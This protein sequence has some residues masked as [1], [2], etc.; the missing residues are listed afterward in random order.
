LW[1]EWRVEIVI[2][3][4]V[5]LAIFLLVEQ[6]NIRQSL[7]AGLRTSVKWLAGLVASAGQTFARLTQATT[8]SDM[9]AYLL[10][11]VVAGLA[12]WR[13]RHR[14]LTL[15]RFSDVACPRCGSELTR[16]HRHRSDRMLSLFVPLRRYQCKN[17]ECAWRG[18]RVYR[19]R[20]GMPASHQ[21]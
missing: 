8:V 11:L 15:P 16:I 21:E 13:T 3:L 17:H 2:A 9:I 1:R 10:L 5:C 20:R 19:S 14:L 7:Y 4:L 6:M 18:L 12:I